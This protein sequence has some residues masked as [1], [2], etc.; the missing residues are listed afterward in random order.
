MNVNTNG[1]FAQQFLQI[2]YFVCRCYCKFRLRFGNNSLN[3]V[4]KRSKSFEDFSAD[5]TVDFQES[6][7][8]KKMSRFNPVASHIVRLPWAIKCAICLIWHVSQTFC[9]VCLLNFACCS[10]CYHLRI[11][12]PKCIL[13]E[14]YVLWDFIMKS[15]QSF[16]CVSVFNVKNGNAIEKKNNF[17]MKNVYPNRCDRLDGEFSIRELSLII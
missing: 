13:D 15:S 9:Y 8:I 7:T 3:V 2:L 11:I 10:K 5:A 4:I 14:L 17:I 1:S 12:H 16:V 6:F